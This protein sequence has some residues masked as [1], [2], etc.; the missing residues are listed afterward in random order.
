MTAAAVHG[1]P[2]L[3]VYALSL[4]LRLG[5]AKKGK[6][7]RETGSER[8]CEGD[9]VA[10]LDLRKMSTAAVVVVVVVKPKNEQKT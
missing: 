4:A 8:G 2:M 10:E 1:C 5:L 9:S 3:K 7:E 6:R